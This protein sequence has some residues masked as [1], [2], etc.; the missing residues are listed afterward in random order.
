MA[1]A[2]CA[3]QGAMASDSGMSDEHVFLLTFL[4]RRC[5]PHRIPVLRGCHSKSQVDGE[6][7]EA[8]HQVH[9]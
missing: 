7:T 2:P 3:A 9:L 6:A 4:S 8:E 5:S 1:L